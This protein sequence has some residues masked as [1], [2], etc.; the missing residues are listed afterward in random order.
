M[1]FLQRK[2]PDDKLLGNDNQLRVGK[3]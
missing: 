2:Y 1:A 3:R